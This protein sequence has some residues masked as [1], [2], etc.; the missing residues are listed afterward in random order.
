MIVGAAVVDFVAT[1]GLAVSVPSPPPST[2]VDGAGVMKTLVDG[3]SVGAVVVRMGTEGDSVG[4][5]V[6]GAVLGWSDGLGVG[7]T[8]GGGETG[9]VVGASVGGRVGDATGGG[10]G[11]REGAMGD[12]VSGTT[13]G[14]GVGGRTAAGEFVGLLSGA[15]RTSGE[16]VGATAGR[17]M[18]D[19]DGRSPRGEAVGG[20]TSTDG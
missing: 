12:L 8:V 2:A 18:G 5:L 1:V 14:L 19:V 3:A 16:G 11:P 10:V 6:G 9:Q 15:T 17:C 20:E 13:A 7:H 4:W